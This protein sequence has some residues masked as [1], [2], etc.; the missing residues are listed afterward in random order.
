MRFRGAQVDMLAF[1]IEV[2]RQSALRS[3]GQ[4]PGAFAQ[5]VDIRAGHG[6]VTLALRSEK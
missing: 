3:F 1:E 5:V 6:K 2:V 4:K